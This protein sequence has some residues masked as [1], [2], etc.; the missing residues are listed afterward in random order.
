[1]IQS[2]IGELL[3][4]AFNAE[5]VTAHLEIPFQEQSYKRLQLGWSFAC[6]QYCGVVLSCP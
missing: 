6:D 5:Y 4:H 2:V 1:M 3:A